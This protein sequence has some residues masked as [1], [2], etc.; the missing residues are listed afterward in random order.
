MQGGTEDR[1]SRGGWVGKEGLQEIL[2]LLGGPLKKLQRGAKFGGLT[3][4]LVGEE[5]TKMSGVW[6]VVMQVM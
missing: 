1:H 4:S 3:L 6:G 5:V 2:E